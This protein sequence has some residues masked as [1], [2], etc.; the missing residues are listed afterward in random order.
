MTDVVWL[1]EDGRRVAGHVTHWEQHATVRL[2]TVRWVG[3]GFRE[4]V[5]VEGREPDELHMQA[6]PR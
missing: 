5:F 6:V 2:F 1:F 3:K 4:G